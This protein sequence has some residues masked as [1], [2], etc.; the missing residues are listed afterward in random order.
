MPAEKGDL[1]QLLNGAIADQQEQKQQVRGKEGPGVTD[2]ENDRL[3]R[4]ATAADRGQLRTAARLPRGSKT[5][6]ANGGESRGDRA[7]PS[8]E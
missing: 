4:A 3:L 7:A 8:S 5:P 2:T 1:E 6:P